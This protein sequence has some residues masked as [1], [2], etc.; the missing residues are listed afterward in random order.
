[1]NKFRH[2]LVQIGDKLYVTNILYKLWFIFLGLRNGIH[3]KFGQNSI[4]LKKSTNSILIRKGKNDFG[5]IGIVLRDFDNFYKTV[6]LP[7]NVK[8]IDFSTP[9]FH[10]VDSGHTFFFHDICEPS[11]TT[12][13]YLEKANLNNCSEVVLDLGSYCGTQTVF[14]SDSVGPKGSVIAFEPD[15]NSYNSL[16]INI[17]QAKNKNI[18]DLSLLEFCVREH[19]NKIAQ[20][21]MVVTNPIKLVITNYD[22]GEEILHSENNPEDPNGGTRDVPFSNELWI[23]REDFMEEPTKKYFRLGPGLSVRLKSA[24]IVSCESFEKDAEG[25]ITT[26]YATYN[27]DSKS[28]QDTSGIPV[29][30]TLH[31][32]SAKHA[33]PVVLNEYDRLFNVEDLASAEGDFKDYMNPISLKKVEAYA[34]PALANDALDARFQFLRKGYFYQDTKSTKDKLV[35]NR[36]VTLKDTWAK[37]QKK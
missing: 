36:T 12:K 29:K 26:V 16:S 34:E 19:L 15:S 23:E 9:K 37:E 20:R 1:M 5:A 4:L 24:Y 35:F 11:T 33:V 17:D 31:W 13:I 22:K 10:V 21:R 8:L 18:I 3:I 27:V 2:Y 25:N 32:V 28:G 14:Y 30:G 6:I 7:N